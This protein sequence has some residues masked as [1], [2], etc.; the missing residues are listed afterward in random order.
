MYLL[1]ILIFFNVYLSLYYFCVFDAII[2]AIFYF[3]KP[4]TM[5]CFHFKKCYHKYLLYYKL[6]FYYIVYLIIRR[7]KKSG[8]LA[9]MLKVISLR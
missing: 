8:L 7:P 3:K 1:F 6:I 4:Q 5:Y 9:K 2:K